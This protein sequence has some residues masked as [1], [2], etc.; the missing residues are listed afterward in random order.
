MITRFYR[1]SFA[2]NSDDENESSNDN[3]IKSYK[4]LILMLPSSKLLMSDSNNSLLSKSEWLSEDEMLDDYI[5]TMKISEFIKNN[6]D[7]DKKYLYTVEKID[8]SIVCGSACYS[9]KV[10]YIRVTLT[11]LLF[12]KSQIN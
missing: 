11:L 2:V 6:W 4:D 7:L 9:Y 8:T 5:A 12:G 1:S 3:F 10:A